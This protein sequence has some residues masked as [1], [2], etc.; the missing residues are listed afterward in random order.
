MKKEKQ[1]IRQPIVTIAGHVDHGKTSILDKF[2]GSKVAEKEAGKITQKISFTSFPSK[3]I[4]KSCHLI[5]IHGIELEIPGF[6]FVDTPGHQA[7]TNLRKRGGSLADL[8]ILVIDINEGIMPQTA[9]VLQILKKNKTPFIIALNK[10][11]RISGWQKKDEDIKKNME[12]QAKHVYEE[13]QQQVYQLIASLQNHGFDSSLFWNIEDFTK[14]I[15][16]VPT[17]AETK[18]GLPELLM[19]LCGLSQKYLT[20]QLKLGKKARGVIFEIKKEKAMNYIEAILHNGKLNKNDEIAIATFDKPVVSKIRVLEEIQPLS[21]KFKPSKQVKAATGIRLQLTETQEIL[22]G[23][24]FQTFENLKEVEKELKKQI[25]EVVKTDDKGITVKADS[26]GSLEALLTLLK[27]NNIKIAKAGIGKIG[28]SDII[29]AKT[30][31]EKEPTYG[32]VL[33]FNVSLDEEVKSEK[34]VKVFTDKIVYKLI[35]NL[36]KWQEQVR[37]EVEREKLNKLANIFKLKILSEYVFRDRNPAIFGVEVK[38]GTL[39]PNSNVIDENDEEIGRIKAVQKENENVDEAKEGEAAISIPGIMFSRQLKNSSYL[40]PDISEKQYREFKK[41]KN[42]LTR[43]EK[44]VL[45]EIANLKR[46]ENPVWGV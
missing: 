3:N 35:E 13:F 15:A 6:L 20:D 5:D 42:L 32:C 18:E 44:G 24:P 40:Y 19:V 28:K 12:N 7:F 41:N 26:L 14:K 25:K 31:K 43:E 39:K 46:E 10:I 21:S 37:K 45:K 9:E 23:M 1:N 27:Q 4:R 34:N 36:E 38:A 17:S 33:G 11:D 29:A 22:P 16:L 30:S 8:A 2:R